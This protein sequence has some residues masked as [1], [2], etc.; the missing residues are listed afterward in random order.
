MI[1]SNENKS[2]IKIN[3]NILK[4]IK[5]RDQKILFHKKY[6]YSSSILIHE[7]TLTEVPYYTNEF[8]TEQ[9]YNIVQVNINIPYTYISD[10]SHGK[11]LTYLDDEMICDSTIY[12]PTNVIRPLTIIGY[13]QNLCKGKHLVKIMACSSVGEGVLNLPHINPKYIEYTLKPVV[14]GSITIIGF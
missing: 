11:I 14:S 12:A 8:I 7:T 5:Y 6:N 9:I 2:K 13:V 4:K 3:E 10:H 1:F